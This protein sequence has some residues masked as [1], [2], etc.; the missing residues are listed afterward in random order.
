MSPARTLLAGAAQALSAAV[1]RLTWLPKLAVG[2]YVVNETSLQ[3]GCAGVSHTRV[4]V[5]ECAHSQE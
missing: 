3:V 1:S 4:T 2:A 5:V